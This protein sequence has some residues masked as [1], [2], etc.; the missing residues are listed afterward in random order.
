MAHTFKIRVHFEK[1]NNM[2]FPGMYAKVIIDLTNELE[3]KM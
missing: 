2:I 3:N 1:K